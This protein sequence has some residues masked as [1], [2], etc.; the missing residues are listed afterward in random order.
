VE[1]LLFFL[2]KIARLRVRCKKL[3]LVYNQTG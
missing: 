2:V 1:S 3:R